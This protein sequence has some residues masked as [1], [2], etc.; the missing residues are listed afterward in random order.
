M[1]SPH[2][3]HVKL[4]PYEFEAEGS[5]AVVKE[6]FS[7]FLDIART[8][9][10]PPP[11]PPPS[12]LPIGDKGNSGNGCNP[13]HSLT[14]D[15]LTRI[16]SVDQEGQVSL[17]ILP[18]TDNRDAD[19]LL[20]L[21]YGFRVLSDQ[22]DVLSGRLLRAMKISGLT[23]NRI[24]RAMAPNNELVTRGGAKTGTRWGLNNRG[25]TK[26]EEIIAGVLR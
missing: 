14:E 1:T 22:M 16:F 18:Q 11:T 15:M 20:I 4:G 21:L 6:Q 3:I 24:D 12:E 10:P 5:E 7:L 19:A 2:K 13:I 17:R 23:I 26:A 25:V 8:P 9:P